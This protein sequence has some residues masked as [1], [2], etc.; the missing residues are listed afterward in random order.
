[1][2]GSSF[3][4]YVH[5]DAEITTSALPTVGEIIS[6]HLEQEVSKDTEPEPVVPTI[7]KAM[8][9]ITILRQFIE[10]GSGGEDAFKALYIVE[11]QEAEIHL[12]K[13]QKQMTILD[14]LK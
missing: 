9:A 8:D 12:Q 1:M 14:F 11:R 3:E 5:D 6:N 13:K 10:S 2:A 7:D 4:D